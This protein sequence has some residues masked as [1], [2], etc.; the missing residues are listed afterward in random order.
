MSY[1]PL[2]LLRSL[3]K[4]L[5]NGEGQAVIYRRVSSVYNATTGVTANTNTDTALTAVV[6]AR[7]SQFVDGT[8][9]HVPG[10]KL[11]ISAV[12]LPTAPEAGD[13]VILAATD[14]A[15][16]RRR[17]VA[18]EIVGTQGTGIVYSVEVEP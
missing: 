6:G 17:V 13:I 10:E 8:L 3:G 14:T 16:A 11:L 7:K 1:A 9:V 4:S 15:S 2:G 5:I 12:D 18:R